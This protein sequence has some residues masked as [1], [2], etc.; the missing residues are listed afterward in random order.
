MLVPRSESAEVSRI[1]DDGSFVERCDVGEILLTAKRRRK[2]FQMFD[3]DHKIGQ[4]LDCQC[5]FFVFQI[6][7]DPQAERFVLSRL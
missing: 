6:F 5:M 1:A 3:L 4:I 7:S 2:D